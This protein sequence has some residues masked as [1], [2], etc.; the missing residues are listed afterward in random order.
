MTFEEIAEQ[1]VLRVGVEVSG[2]VHLML[3]ILENFKKR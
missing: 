2:W 1:T 3:D